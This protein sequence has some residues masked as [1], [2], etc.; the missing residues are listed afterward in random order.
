MNKMENLDVKISM[1]PIEIIKIIL[2]F[3]YNFQPKCLL[4]DIKQFSVIKSEL[5]CMY[6]TI[7]HDEYGDWIINDI[8]SYVN[9]YQATMIGYHDKFYNILWRRIGMKTNLQIDNYFEIIETKSVF[10]QINILLGLLTVEE[11]N[12]FMTRTINE[13]QH[14]D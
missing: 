3:T 10:S 1:L 6:Q 14:Y 11:R 8:I 2:S 4:N 7:W 5:F 13:F 12:E 9:N